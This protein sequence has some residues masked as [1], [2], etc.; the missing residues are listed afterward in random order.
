MLLV[1]SAVFEEKVEVYR[2]GIGQYMLSGH[3]HLSLAT[4]QM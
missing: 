1:R 3:Q 2:V 4:C